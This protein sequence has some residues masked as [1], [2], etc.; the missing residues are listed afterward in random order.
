MRLKIYLSMILLFL[1]ISITN[2]QSNYYYKGKKKAPIKLDRQPLTASVFKDLKKDSLKNIQILSPLSSYSLRS[3]STT[4][5]ATDP[6][7]N[8]QWGLLNSRRPTIDINVCEAWEITEGEGVQVAVLDHGVELTHDDLE[9]NLSSMSY[10]TRSGTSPSQEYTG[11]HGTSLGTKYAGIIAAVKGNDIGIVGVAPQSTLISISNPFSD[12]YAFST[13]MAELSDGMNWAWKNGADIINNR[14]GSNR[15]YDVVDNAINDAL[16]KGRGGKG[17]VLVFSSGINGSSFIGYPTNLSPDILVV[18]S[19][20]SIGMRSN[21]SNYGNKLD[22]V[23]P[24]E[25]NLTTEADNSIIVLEDKAGEAFVSGV[26]AL[27]LSANPSLSVHQVSDIIEQTAQKIR[28]DVYTYTNH[29]NRPNGTWNNEVGYGLVDAYAAVQ[30]A[31]KSKLELWLKTNEG[32]VSWT[33]QSGNGVRVTPEGAIATASELNFN[34]TN[35]FGSSAYYDTNLDISGGDKPFLSVT[36]VYIPTSNSSG[37]LWGEGDGQNTDGRADRVMLDWKIRAGRWNNTIGAGG[38]FLFDVNNL[39]VQDAPTITTVIFDEDVPDGSFAYVNGK[40]E[41]TFTSNHAPGTSNLFEIG[42]TGRESST[43]NGRIAEIMVHSRSFNRNQV[44]SYLALKYGVSLDQTEGQSYVNS[45]GTEIYDADGTFGGFDHDIIGIGQDDGSSLDQRISKSINPGSILILSHDKDFTSANNDAVRTSLGNGNFLITGHN[46]GSVS[47]DNDFVGLPHSLMSRVWAFDKTGTVGEVYVVIKKS[48]LVLNGKLYAV[49]SNDQTFDHS[50]T[51][52]E[53]VGDG[54][55]WHGTMT[56]SDSD[57]MSFISISEPGGISNNIVAWLKSEIGTNTTIDGNDVTL[58]RNSVL[59]PVYD[60]RSFNTL[61]YTADGFTTTLSS[62]PPSYESDVDNL[63]N[64]HPSILFENNPDFIVGD[65]YTGERLF[66]KVVD[67]ASTLLDAQPIES[68]TLYA[69]GSPKGMWFNEFWS[70]F[71]NDK[72]LISNERPIGI[73][74]LSSKIHFSQSGKVDGNFVEKNF[75]S[76]TI[77]ERG[78]IALLKVTIPNATT[79]SVTYNK[80]G[81]ADDIINDVYVGGGYYHILGNVGSL[82]NGNYFD[83]PF[84]NIAETIIYGTASLSDVENSRIESYLALKYG[85]TLDQT[86][87]QSYINSHGVEIYDADG[88]FND[89]DHNIIGIGK[90]I[91]SS[92]DQRV[93]KSVHSGAVLTLATTKDFTGANNNEDRISLEDESFLVT[94][95]N[96]ESVVFERFFNG[97][98]NAMINRIWA[99]EETGT[100]G[101]VYV[102]IPISGFNIH[103]SNLY[104]V[105]SENQTFDSSD[106]VFKMIRNN[107][108]WFA[109]INPNNGNFMTFVSTDANLQFD[110]YIKDSPDDSGIEPN[111]ITKKFWRSPDIWVRNVPDGIEEHQNPVYSPNIPNYVYVRVQNRSSIASIGNDQVKLYWRKAGT[112]SIWPESWDGSAN[113]ENGTSASGLIGTVTIPVLNP[114]EEIILSIPWKTPNPRDYSNI[115]PHL[116]F[117]LLA[118]IVSEGDPMTDEEEGVYTT[119]NA[120]RNNNIA[121]K[122]VTVVKSSSNKK[123]NAKQSKFGSFGGTISVGNPFNEAKTFSLELIKEES[124]T[125]KAIFDVAE[126]SLEMNKTLYNAWN[127]GGKQSELLK[128]T[129]DEKKKLVK[130]N[131]ATLNNLRFAPNEMGTLNVSF[132]F[133]AKELT[134]KSEFVYH[135]VQKE[136]ETGEVIGGETYVI[137]KDLQVETEGSVKEDRKLEINNK[138]IS[139]GKASFDK[140]IPNPASNTVRFTYN[141]GGAKSAYLTVTGFYHGATKTST[142]YD[143]DINSRETTLDLTNY[144]GGHYQV[145]LVCD[146]KIV[147]AKTLIKE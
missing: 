147:E 101:D 3:S 127:R 65:N 15:Q 56:P 60:L 1:S 22:V 30:L 11:I 132:N 141:L 76:N 143:L 43:F 79:T 7:F 46:E 139:I 91:E 39:F 75:S 9:D 140:I 144:S 122:N 115:N 24:G 34:P 44:E 62:I 100:I 98:E 116:H 125:G 19:V 118:R 112:V 74:S 90:D 51:F 80:N 5:C 142:N 99:F 105:L 55:F 119:R 104:A 120:K 86:T 63:L 21:Y 13:R 31:K 49:L 110:L 121:W 124:E 42:R 113:F 16:T 85:I 109:K 146:G 66:S 61:E 2:A 123:K 48:D 45:E 52:V 82:S 106:R 71:D 14:W 111:Q 20:D 36:S 97:E 128:N 108:F 117:C 145:A 17:S 32:G 72:P 50:D 83:S 41:R 58:W 25:D 126:V 88:A 77:W 64:F 18:G 102:S 78:E 96:G 138:T 29:S 136:A 57:Y 47:F 40:L 114:G 93:S 92:L 87:P 8:Q 84:G 94:G 73:G 28:T 53:M 12:N 54:V 107:G 103:G 133:L 37:G 6:Y 35:L 4:P 23:A 134:D 81:G 95:N 69:V 33:D 137:N 135:V 59:N 27:V 89:F 70:G 131:H 68:T 38:E 10:D 26:A 130:S 67:N 129:N